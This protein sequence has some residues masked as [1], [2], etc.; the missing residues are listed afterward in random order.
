[1]AAKKIKK[2]NQQNHNSKKKLSNIY[3]M[4]RK[5]IEKWN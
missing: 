3:E 2:K 1:M 5:N 4:R